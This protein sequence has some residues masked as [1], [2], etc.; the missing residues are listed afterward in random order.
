MKYQLLV[1]SFRFILLIACISTKEQNIDVERKRK[2]EDPIR[3]EDLQD[4]KLKF[5]FA[6]MFSA[7]SELV[8]FR[9]DASLLSKPTTA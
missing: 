9:R 7:I 5:K 3:Y 6:R 8:V 2:M 1:K 4:I